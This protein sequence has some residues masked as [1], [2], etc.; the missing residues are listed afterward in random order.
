MQGVRFALS[1]GSVMVAT[2]TCSCG[3][4]CLSP[5]LIIF[6]G[7]RA[8]L[9]NGSTL[10]ELGLQTAIKDY[11][12]GVIYLPCDL[13]LGKEVACFV[14]RKSKEASQRTLSRDCYP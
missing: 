14:C 8:G 6:L 5:R 11:A 13:H 3:T 12:M 9:R 4:H 10:Q 7:V 2:I 1:T